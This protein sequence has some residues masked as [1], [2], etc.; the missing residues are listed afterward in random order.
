MCSLTAASQWVD[1]ETK[2]LGVFLFPEC[3]KQAY[4]AAAWGGGTTAGQWE[5]RQEPGLSLQAQQ[6]ALSEKA[7]PTLP[8]AAAHSIPMLCVDC[9]H[10][11]C[12]P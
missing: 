5:L 7:N 2:I 8:C 1:L 6:W 4:G 11:L 9:F 3:Q 10:T 12:F